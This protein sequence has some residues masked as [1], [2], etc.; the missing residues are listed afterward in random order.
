MNDAKKQ[1]IDYYHTKESKLGYKLILGGTKHFGYYPNGKK[2]ISMRHAM[3]LMID[4]LG[5]TLA[6]PENSLVLDAGCGEGATALRIAEKYKLKV[7]GIDLLDF[8]IQS[9]NK[10]LTKSGLKERV[11]FSVGDYSKL[12]FPDNHFDAVYTLETLVH[13]PDYKVTLK[14]FHRVLKQNGKLVLFEYS[15][16]KDK[17]LTKEQREAY[18]NINIGSAMHSF[19]SFTHGSF[20]RLLSAEGFENVR[21]KDITKH[22]MPMSRKFWLLGWMPY[23]LIKLARKQR[24][25][26]NTTAGVELYKHRDTFRYNIVTAHKH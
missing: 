9:A 8:N 16:P 25:Y 10:R 22:M 5:D 24:K 20:P 12:K 18:K 21:V 2:H 4:K 7:E 3:R 15:M 17:E 11:R 19:P 14:E 23:R 13:S 1:V 6:L 26:A